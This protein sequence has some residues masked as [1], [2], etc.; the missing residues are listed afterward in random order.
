MYNLSFEFMF[1][2]HA[3]TPETNDK[4]VQVLEESKASESV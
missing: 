3:N 2:S 4:L 1:Q